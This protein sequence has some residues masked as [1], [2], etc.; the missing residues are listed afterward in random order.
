MKRYFAL[1][2]ERQRDCDRTVELG[3]TRRNSLSMVSA[4]MMRIVD[5]IW[6]DES[7]PTY[8]V[9]GIPPEITYE[10]LNRDAYNRGKSEKAA[11]ASKLVSRSD[12]ATLRVAAMLHQSSGKRPHHSIARNARKTGPGITDSRLPVFLRRK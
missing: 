6:S 9:F 2:E 11:G 4:G 12:R 5:G 3:I 10:I 7:Y 8:S 1:D